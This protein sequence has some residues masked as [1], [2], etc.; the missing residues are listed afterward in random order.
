MKMAEIKAKR[1]RLNIPIPEQEKCPVII[2]ESTIFIRISTEMCRGASRL[3]EHYYIEGDN[4]RSVGSL[5]RDVTYCFPY[6]R[7]LMDNLKCLHIV[8]SDTKKSDDFDKFLYT[9]W[10]LPQD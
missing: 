5:V 4:Q 3:F 1:R 7:I 6:Y 10:P 2:L 8:F 9:P